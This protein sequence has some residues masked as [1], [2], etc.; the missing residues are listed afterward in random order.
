MRGQYRDDS[1]SQQRSMVSNVLVQQARQSELKKYQYLI[2]IR[3]FFYYYL[4]LYLY[5]RNF[6]TGPLGA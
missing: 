5:V 3:Y 1:E 2:Y 6:Q 4:S